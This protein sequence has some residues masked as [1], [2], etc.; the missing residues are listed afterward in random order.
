M[1][2]FAYGCVEGFVGEGGVFGTTDE[3][4]LWTGVNEDDSDVDDDAV[5][6]DDREEPLD[7]IESSELDDALR[8]VW[9]KCLDFVEEG[10]DKCG[11]CICSIVP[12]ERSGRGEVSS[13][14]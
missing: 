9:G 11:R 10:E 14:R 7:V 6:D 8:P 13:I 12:T 5:V 2:G 1:R 3:D 4:L